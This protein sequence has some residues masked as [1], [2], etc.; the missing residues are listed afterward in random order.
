MSRFDLLPM[1]AVDS[2]THMQAGMCNPRSF[3]IILFLLIGAMAQA[4]EDVIL[5]SDYIDH[6]GAIRNVLGRY[7]IMIYR[8]FNFDPFSGYYAEIPA[9]QRAQEV[10]HSK[11]TGS[12]AFVPDP[13]TLQSTRPDRRIIILNNSLQLINRPPASHWHFVPP[14]LLTTTVHA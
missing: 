12:N 13:F 7:D 14:P 6:T 4:Q 10:L 5:G 3:F 11:V 2:V 8:G 1:L 9:L